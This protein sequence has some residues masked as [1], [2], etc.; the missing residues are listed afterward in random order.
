MPKEPKGL[1]V[2]REEGRLRLTYRNHRG[3]GCFLL[4]A[5]LFWFALLPSC[6]A[7]LATGDG[8]GG[9]EI[10]AF[11][12]FLLVAVSFSYAGLAKLLNRTELEFT[13]DTVSVSHLPLPWP[14]S[15]SLE[16]ASIKGYRVKLDMKPADIRHRVTVG[17]IAERFCGKPAAL[18]RAI[19]DSKAARRMHEEADAFLKEIRQ[20]ESG[21][22]PPVG[23]N[24][25]A[26]PDS[27]GR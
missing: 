20:T 21:P 11:L 13:R 4:F 9:G 12:P 1:T 10:L 19:N 8:F 5:G 23:Q 7:F 17:L 25:A 14:G 18:L 6:F 24:E 15:L 2:S 22:R 16:T 27:G 26:A 3:T